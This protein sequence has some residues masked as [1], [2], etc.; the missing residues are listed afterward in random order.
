MI[1]ETVIITGVVE[2]FDPEIESPLVLR[3][4][5]GLMMIETVGQVPEAIVGRRIRISV[6]MLLLYP[7]HT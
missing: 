1:D 4:G 2:E 3:V 6:A 5:S 7:T